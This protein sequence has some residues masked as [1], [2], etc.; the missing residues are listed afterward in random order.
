MRQ[1]ENDTIGIL[2]NSKNTPHPP[3]PCSGLS[4]YMAP[5]ILCFPGRDLAGL[6]RT[7]GSRVHTRAFRQSLMASEPRGAEYPV[8]A[9]LLNNGVLLKLFRCSYVFMW[10][11]VWTTSDGMQV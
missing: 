7:H 8:V 4:E 9:K 6:G 5:R 1:T 3:S 2:S 10:R 11:T